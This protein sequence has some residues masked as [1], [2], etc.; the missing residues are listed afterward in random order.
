MCDPDSGQLGR[1]ALERAF[2]FL[3]PYPAG[4]EVAPGESA[5]GDGA[6]GNRDRGPHRATL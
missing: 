3:E 1:Q 4:L 2:E 5:C 6:G